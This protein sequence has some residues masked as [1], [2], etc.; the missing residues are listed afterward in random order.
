[1][2]LRELFEDAKNIAEKDPASKSVITVILL[3]SGFHILVFHRL[4]HW[5]Y[6]HKLFFLARFVSQLR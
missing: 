6:I 5:L 2:F 1:M 4:A 3:Y